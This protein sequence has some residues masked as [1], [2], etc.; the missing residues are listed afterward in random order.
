MKRI[1]AIGVCLAAAALAWPVP[2]ITGAPSFERSAPRRVQLLDV[3]Y[4]PQSG[5]LCGGAA[6]AMVLR[7]WGEPGVFAEDFAA[8]VQ[9]GDAG[10]RTG[11]LV[12]AVDARGWTALPLP[13][14]PAEVEDHLARG[15]PIITLIRSGSNS[16]HYVVLV[17]RA[18]GW[19]ILHDPLAGPFRAMRESEFDA[20]WSASGGWALLIL[21]PRG[22]DEEGAPDLGP[23]RTPDLTPDRAQD[24]ARVVHSS[25]A[26]S[27]DCGVMVEAGIISAAHGND[28]EAERTFLA[29]HSLC[30]ASAAP[31]RELAGL[32]FRA[33]DWAGA[34]RLAG[35]ALELDSSDTNAR[36]ILAGS[37][38]LMGDVEGAL[39]AWNHLSEP[40]TDLTRIDGLTRIRY[41]AVTD[42]LDLPPGRLLTPRSF[43]QA[44]RRLAEVPAQSGFRLSL[45]PLPEGNAQVNVTLLE[46]PA[47]FDGPWD[48]G[49]VGIKALTRREITLDVASPTG[50]GELWTAGWRWWTNRPRVSL[51]LAVPAAGRRPGIWRLDGYWEQQTYA[52][53]YSVSSDTTEEEVGREERR[54]TALSFSDWL[55]PDFRFEIG[56]A[57]DKWVDR[58]SHVSLEG[59]IEI[60]LWRDRLGFGARGAG[61]AALAGGAPF[62]AG[63]LSMRWCSDGVERGEA[64]QARF[65][66]ATTTSQAPL[67]LWSGAGT[68][69]GRAPL[70]RA[71]PLLDDGVV[72]GRA[73]GRTLLHG[74]IEKQAWFAGVGPLQIG[75][76]LF[77]DGAKPWHT[78]RADRVPWQVDGGTG[79]R[80]RGPGMNGQFRI[81]A[82]RGFND[83]SSALSVA[84]QVR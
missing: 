72:Q 21:P 49:S 3:P 31:L 51:S 50:N 32:R 80:L 8:L 65:G 46:R 64:W 10:I 26:A 73:F 82:A 60:R 63:D 42:Q 79:L 57:L 12:Q 23:G 18:N 6:V 58:G 53:A 39:R 67:A 5:E 16:F 41:S 30:P 38:F 55:G 24:P 61:W 75:W 81:D 48:V 27:D 83:G 2:A 13:G 37:C 45:R 9:P 62:Q 76:A 47:V 70:L 35:R 56:A 74:T 54:R 34:S 15:R 40:R 68:G 52:G 25:F 7:Y 22:A 1:G 84:W 14:T 44:R 77:A 28:A 19:V 69:Y 33:E 78:G 17:A 59:S 36:R 29:A 66:I 20:A 4:V 11:A 43:R 71:H